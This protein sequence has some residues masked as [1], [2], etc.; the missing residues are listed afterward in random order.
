MIVGIK[1]MAIP[2]HTFILTLRSSM[3]AGIGGVI[4]GRTL[5]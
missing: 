3:L 2:A 5:P 4:G 1:W